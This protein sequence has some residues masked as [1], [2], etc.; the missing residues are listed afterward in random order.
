M[1]FDPAYDRWRKADDLRTGE[2]LTGA[3]VRLPRHG[4]FNGTSVFLRRRDGEVLALP[5][6]ASKG[7]TVLER[8][9]GDVRV[10]DEVA[11]TYKGRRTTRDGERQY[12]DY[13]LQV[14]RPR[15][16]TDLRDLRSSALEDQ[17]P[18]WWAAA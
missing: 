13:D 1:S 6:A 5:A 3:V 15:T 14:L 7:H 8:L 10:G 11:I 17:N 9:L 2:T 18:P 4:A 12:R 16:V